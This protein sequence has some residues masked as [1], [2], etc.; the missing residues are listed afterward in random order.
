MAVPTKVVDLPVKQIFIRSDRKKT[1][2]IKDEKIQ[3]MVN[4]VELSGFLEPIG[5]RPS[6]DNKYELLYGRKRL[7]IAK[8]LGYDTIPAVI[9]ENVADEQVDFITFSENVHRAQLTPAQWISQVQ[10][11]ARAREKRGIIVNGQSDA[12]I[13]RAENAVREGGRFAKGKKETDKKDALPKDP[14]LPPPASGFTPQAGGEPS[15]PGN[16]KPVSFAKEIAKKSGRD[17]RT[18]E[19]DIKLA[20]T[21]T[22]EQLKDLDETNITRD[23]LVK[24]G[25]IEN[26]FQRNAVIK[27]YV[28]CE[29]TMSVDELIGDIVGSSEVIKLEAAVEENAMPDAQWLEVYCGKVRSQIQDTRIYDIDALLYRESRSARAKFAQGIKAK[30]LKARSKG[31]PPFSSQLLKVLF[32]DHPGAW[33]VCCECTGDNV[34]HPKCSFCHGKGYTV[35]CR[36]IPRAKD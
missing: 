3:L 29:G 21:L 26:E 25:D 13:A 31:Y 27:S 18:A 20:N 23:D 11:L 12:G 2:T 16:E 7:W 33:Y 34:D 15:C 32:V 9:K 19:R 14:S 28:C 4:D 5:V 10:N 1:I 24:I 17:I 22:A 30:A 36:D 35:R 8:H 6:L